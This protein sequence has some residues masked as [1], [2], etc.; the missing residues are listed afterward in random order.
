MGKPYRTIIDL[1]TVGKKDKDFFRFS[2]LCPDQPVVHTD[3]RVL[4]RLLLILLKSGEK[5]KNRVEDL[6]NNTPRKP[7]NGQIAFLPGDG[8][9]ERMPHRSSIVYL[10]ASF[11]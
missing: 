8:D 4:E 3:D 11:R 10:P 1:K 6:Q 7:T 2:L 9:R 5:H